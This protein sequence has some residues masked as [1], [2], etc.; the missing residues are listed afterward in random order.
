MYKVKYKVENAAKTI[1]MI[2]TGDLFEWVKSEAWPSTK[3]PKIFPISYNDIR[4]AI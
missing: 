2:A 4:L 1:A 3:P